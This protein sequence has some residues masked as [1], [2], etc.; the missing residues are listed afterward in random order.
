M[1]TNQPSYR[2][3]ANL[4]DR[5]PFENGALLFVDSTGVYSPELVILAGEPDAHKFTVSRLCLDRCAMLANNPAT[6]SGNRYH[7]DQPAWFADKLPA[8]ASF[9]GR[10]TEDLAKALVSSNPVELAGAYIALA[11]YFGCHE[12][13]SYPVEMT[14]GEIK[15][16]YRAAFRKA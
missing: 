7:A 13:D 10:T 5:N 1:K 11:G 16:R 2:F 9:V 15:R 6:L 3:V 14:R 8:V 4:G 12:F